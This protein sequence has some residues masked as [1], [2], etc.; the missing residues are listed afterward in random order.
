MPN[1]IESVV[2]RKCNVSYKQSKQIVAMARDFLR[3][4]PDSNLLWSKELENACILVYNNTNC[5]ESVAATAPKSEPLAKQSLHKTK[6]SSNMKKDPLERPVTKERKARSLSKSRT[7]STSKSPTKN[8]ENSDPR[9]RNSRS[10]EPITTSSSHRPSSSRIRRLEDVS[11][12]DILIKSARNVQR[13]DESKDVLST[14]PKRTVSENS[15]HSKTSDRSQSSKSPSS[16][17]SRRSK[18]RSVR[19]VDNSVPD[20]HPKES[21][22]TSSELLRRSRGTSNSESL[23]EREKRDK[24][25]H[26]SSRKCSLVPTDC[27]LPDMERR[28]RATS[29]DR[30]P[31]RS[32]EGA[33]TSEKSARRLSSPESPSARLSRSKNDSSRIKLNRNDS[34]AIDKSSHHQSSSRE[35]DSKRSNLNLKSKWLTAEAKTKGERWDEKE[36]SW[37]RSCS[38]SSAKSMSR[39]RHTKTIIIDSDDDSSSGS[40]ACTSKPS[41]VRKLQPT[42]N[43]S[44]KVPTPV[45]RRPRSPGPRIGANSEYDTLKTMPPVTLNGKSNHS[46]RSEHSMRRTAEESFSQTERKVKRK[47]VSPAPEHRP[48]KKDQASPPS[49]TL[50]ARPPST[51]CTSG[52]SGIPLNKKP[53]VS[54]RRLS[55]EEVAKAC[56]ADP[57]LRDAIVANFGRDSGGIRLGTYRASPKVTGPGDEFTKSFEEWEEH[58][59]DSSESASAPSKPSALQQYHMDNPL[60]TFIGKVSNK[61]NSNKDENTVSTGSES[62]TKSKTRMIPVMKNARPPAK[63][64]IPKDG[65]T[66]PSSVEPTHLGKNTSFSNMTMMSTDFEDPFVAKK[67]EAPKNRSRSVGAKPIETTCNA[68][69]VAGCSIGESVLSRTSNT[70][71]TT[72]SSSKDDSEED[73]PIVDYSVSTFFHDEYSEDQI[74]P[75]FSKRFAKPNGLKRKESVRVSS[76]TENTL[77]SWEESSPMSTK[78]STSMSSRSSLGPPKLPQRQL[79][80]VGSWR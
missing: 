52:V 10:R 16:S 56:E 40:F 66:E 15:S 3:L 23:S 61:S 54:R 51:K 4:S 45:T 62:S 20:L 2:M 27:E 17:S 37:V 11:N 59:D 60:S 46:V 69:N 26:K 71:E 55:M 72:C 78:S 67:K 76:R 6:S 25:S 42:E 21:K 32:S 68:S 64:S 80:I 73:I 5:E 57:K 65:T 77:S 38:V 7:R 39:G 28:Y 47:S 14:R 50:L 41:I 31:Q 74:F 13:P 36:E 30:G 19:N 63:K 22:R 44:S 75:E 48:S 58:N 9:S 53:A 1:M 12:S 24:L 33:D 70:T 49:P 35:P 79:S 34:V 18:S 43:R 29:Q 8:S